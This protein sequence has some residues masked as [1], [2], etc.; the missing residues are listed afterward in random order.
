MKVLF[1]SDVAAPRVNGVSTSIATFR[2]DLEALGVETRLVA[3]RYDGGRVVAS[4]GSEWRVPGRRIPLDPEDRLMLRRALGQALDVAL[5][6]VDLVHIQTPFLAH[7]AGL[8]AARRRGLAV[9]ETH[10]TDFEA[11][12]EHYLPWLPAAWLRA[13]GRL[14][15]RNRL[16][17]VDAVVVPSTAI[18]DQL[19]RL[20]VV[21]KI[22]QIPTGLTVP[23]PGRGDGRAF[24]ERHQI[25]L[26]RPCLV[27]VGRLAHEKNVAFLLETYARVHL[28]L[29]EAL[30]V[31]AGEGP[32]RASLQKR[33]IELGIADD[34]LFVGYLDRDRELLDCYRAGDI[35]VFASRT[36]TQ[37]LVLLEAMA[38][39]VPVVSTAVGG[40]RDLLSAERGAVVVEEN[41]ETFARACVELLGDRERRER[42]GREGRSE[43][44][45]RWSARACGERMLSLYREVLD[46]RR[47][48]P[49]VV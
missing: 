5:D 2:A 42:L 43:V 28:A 6:G 26:E 38:L 13:L 22:A 37:G 10:H 24:R 40:T 47:V 1:V 4:D 44:E 15:L 41:V 49:A 21:G 27:H 16:G 45:A 31:I 23:E 8:A 18:A 14:V 3:P 46:E 12:G 11:Y 32:A 39:G 20:G 30:L 7:S 48:P 25:A 17:A 36:E 35:F 33:A 29:P 34:I 19:R 9:V